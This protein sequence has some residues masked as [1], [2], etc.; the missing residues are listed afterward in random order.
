[1]VIWEAT[2]IGQPYSKANSRQ[3]IRDRRTG[4]ER[5]IKS[6]EA[7]KYAE[8]FATQAAFFKPVGGRPYEGQVRVVIGVW[9]KSWQPD[10][11]VSLILDLLQGVAYKNDRQVV[12]QLLYRFD[13]DA[14]NPRARIR[15][16]TTEWPISEG[17]VFD[18]A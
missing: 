11:D 5:F 8:S 18:G 3:K 2:I 1:V 12:E 10:L 4:K 17:S 16:E 13:N 14:R 9:Y 7:R 6:P 15:V